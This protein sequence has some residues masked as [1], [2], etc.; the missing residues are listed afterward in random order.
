MKN[1]TKLIFIIYFNNLIAQ[2]DLSFG[3]INYKKSILGSYFENVNLTDNF[4]L[5]GLKSNMPLY[6]HFDDLDNDPKNYN[7]TLIHCDENWIASNLFESEYIEGYSEEMITEYKYSKNTDFEYIHYRFAV[8]GNNMKITKSGNY[9]V[10]VYE[11]FDKSKLVLT[12]QIYIVDNDL[13]IDI[14]PQI[15]NQTDKRLS[16][17]Q[18]DGDIDISDLQSM[19]P[20]EELSFRLVKN[21]DYK[22]DYIH[23]NINYISNQTAQILPFLNQISAGNEF[24]MFDI[25]RYDRG[26]LGVYDMV[27]KD[28]YR[29]IIL[30]PTDIRS[31]QPYTR[32]LD[33]N[34]KQFLIGESWQNNIYETDYSF[35]HFYLNSP[36]KIENGDI[37]IF[38][39]LTGWEYIPEAIMK[40]NENT[41]QYVGKLLLKQGLYDYAFVHISENNKNANWNLIEGNFAEANNDYLLFVYYKPASANYQKLIGVKRFRFFE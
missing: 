5:I 33:H 1:I 21:N 3:N 13:I 26:T 18:F 25:R 7:F 23:L 4:P 11:D 16:H 39:E 15:S 30:T 17:H 19:N 28:G 32:Y 8:P 35:V 24:R 2:N 10:L 38:G 37:Y 41:K 12:K 14:K 27:R 9:I 29:N 31:N 20:A 6:I 34:G 40:Y 22:K 36:Q